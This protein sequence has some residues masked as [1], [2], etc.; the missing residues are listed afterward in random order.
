MTIVPGEDLVALLRQFVAAVAQVRGVVLVSADGLPT[1]GHGLDE[2]AT[3]TLAATATGLWSLTR[4]AGKAFDGSIQ[5]R[6]VACE[7]QSSTLFVIAAADGSRLAVLADRTA[8]P[9]VVAYEMGM[10]ITKLGA[11]LATAARH[12]DA[13]P[14]DPTRPDPTRPDHTPAA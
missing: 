5:V 14:P 9:E 7:L 12:H 4:E 10:L 8:R 11:H 2:A 3:D 13:A 6:Q 1:A